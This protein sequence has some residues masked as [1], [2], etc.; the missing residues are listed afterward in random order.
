MLAGCLRVSIIHRT[1]TRTTGYLTCAQMLTHAIAH[2]GCTDTVRESALKVDWEKNP[3][4]HRG[5]EPATAGYST[6]WTRRPHL[7]TVLRPQMT[8]AVDWVLP[9]KT[10]SIATGNSSNSP[11]PLP[12]KPADRIAPCS[13]TGL[14]PDVRGSFLFLFFRTFLL[15]RGTWFL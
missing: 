2:E 14:I 4:P 10:Q 13:S 6:N 5:I 8:F 12:E 7:V 3:L 15:C 11:P 9:T 1:L